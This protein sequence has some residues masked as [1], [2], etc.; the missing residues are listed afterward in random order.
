[1]DEFTRAD[2]AA[3][4]QSPPFADFN[5]F[6]IDAPLAGA[7]G[8][9]VCRVHRD[10]LREMGRIAGAAATQRLARDA[11]T[12]TPV[13]RS[14]DARG[15]RIDRIE[16]HP[17]Y[18]QLM[19]ISV[20]AG[21]H[22]ARW[23]PGREAGSGRVTARAA[24]FYMMAQGETGHL[25]PITM[26]HAAGAA[27]ASAPDVSA[28]WL[29]RITSNAYDARDLPGHQKT[30]VTFGMGLTE[31]QGGTDVW[32]NTTEAKPEWD[33]LFRLFGQK[34]FFSAPM[35]DAFLFL[36]QAPGGLSCFVVP[37]RQDN[38]APNGLIIERLKDKMGNRSNASSEVRID[39]AIGR[40]VG[41]E[42]RGVPVILEMA[43]MTR[44]DC[45]LASAGLMRAG[46]A[47]A[48]HHA[49]HRKV[50]GEYLAGQPLMRVVLADL[51][52]E[53]EASV[54]LAM[55]V[56]AAY[57]YE[58]D[59]AKRYR[60]IMT[61][62]AK[63]WICKRSPPALAEAMEALGGNGY[64]EELSLA[65]HY[66][67]APVNSIWEGSGNVMCLD[68][69]RSFRNSREEFVSVLDEFCSNSGAATASRDDVIAHLS[70]A[71]NAEATARIASETIA[72]MAIQSLLEN[73]APGYV[74][75]AHKSARLGS[76][77]STFAAGHVLAAGDADKLLARAL[78]V[79]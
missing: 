40:L 70:D 15:T 45:A 51:A 10:D 22:S 63:Y 68:V 32:T 57:E 36:A 69:L 64:V 72:L 50:F 34:W 19:S 79:S 47:S 43:S 4:N 11:N 38:G 42:G 61:P 53:V 29:P 23:A 74:A 65:R 78:P 59:E 56:A 46:L 60:R 14:V 35:S 73:Q 58:T 67:E 28:V 6:D 52:L 33:G 5:L 20:G 13:L 12:S 21:L 16:F 1:M 27:L 30:G 48:L 54:A 37:R 71:E 2:R 62:V 39:G 55:N 25:C 26:T 49:R 31:R 8:E 18:H 7:I 44:L 76:M 24:A 3:A 75:E 41:E 77:G 17:A 9:E 66:R